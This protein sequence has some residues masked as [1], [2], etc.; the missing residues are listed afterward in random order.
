MFPNGY[1]FF[2]S[3][4]YSTIWHFPLGIT[5]YLALFTPLST[6][7]PE[8]SVGQ[9]V[10]KKILPE[11]DATHHFGEFLVCRILTWGEENVKLIFIVIRGVFKAINL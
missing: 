7:T 10:V 11:S 4:T 3:A 1:I 6:P 8:L 9:T 2:I 5:C